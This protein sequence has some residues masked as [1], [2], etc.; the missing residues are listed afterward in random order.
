MKSTRISRNM[1]RPASTEPH[2]N[3]EGDRNTSETTAAVDKV[4]FKGYNKGS[5]NNYQ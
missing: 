1:A 2:M 3:H 4:P 5:E